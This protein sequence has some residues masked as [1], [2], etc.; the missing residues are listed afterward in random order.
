MHLPEFEHLRPASMEEVVHHLKEY[1]P[2]A[3]LAAGGTDLYPRMKYGL[4]RPDVVISL[5]GLPV[6]PPTVN[7][8][9]DLQLDALM[10]LA[11]VARSPAIRAR[12]PLLNEAALSVG[13]NQIRHMGTLGG[14]LCLENRCSYY[15]QTHTFQ[16]VEPCFK[17]NGDRCY[18]IPDG[19][20]CWAIFAADTVPALISLGAVVNITGHEKDRQMPLESLYTG[21]ALKPLAISDNEIVTKVI[22]LDKVALRGSAFV[23]FTMRGGMEFAALDAAVVLDMEE[24]GVLCREARITLGSISSAPIRALK[25]EETLARQH[26][27]GELFREVAQVVASEARPFPHHGYSTNFLKECLRV[28]TLRAL[29]VASEG[30]KRVQRRI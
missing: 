27:S 8:N 18:F 13:S 30:I 3:R 4:A 20:K 1:G 23:K 14:N 25:G 9:R 29:T 21:D 17:R 26:L 12:I 5:K 15:N 10:T 24:D 19:K 28:Q 11:D 16:F 6:K 22:V 2:R 7:G